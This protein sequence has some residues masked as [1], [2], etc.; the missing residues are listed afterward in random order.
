MAALQLAI[1]NSTRTVSIKFPLCSPTQL[2][3]TP[4]RKLSFEV[5]SSVQ[6]IAVEEKPEKTQQP[7]QRRKLFVLNLPWSYAVADIKNLFGEC[8]TVVDVE[9]IKQKDGKNRGFAFVTMASAEEAQAVIEKF[10]SNELLGRII[11][12]EFAKRFKKPLRSPPAPASPPPRETRHK[13]Y[14]SNLAWKARSTHLRELFSANFEPVSARVVFDS[15]SGRSGGYGFVSF[16]T[17]EEAEAALSALDGKELLGRPISLK[18]SEKNIDEPAKKEEGM[19]DEQP[20][21]ID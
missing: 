20:A 4:T 10:D 16:A 19:T 5:C 3:L 17:K 21:V 12:I 7:D 11:R 18:I 6:E 9:F 1:S 13:L 15:P 14:V 2:S 8:G